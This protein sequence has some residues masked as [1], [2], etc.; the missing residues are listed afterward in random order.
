[1]LRQASVSDLI[2]DRVS[3]GKKSHVVIAMRRYPRFINR[4]LRDEYLPSLASDHE[5]FEDWLATKRRTGDHDGAFAKVKFEDRFELGE[6]GLENLER[7][8]R[9][10]RGKD[11]YV[12]C[13]C[14]RGQRCHREMVLLLAHERFGAPIE[15]VANAYPR[16]VRKLARA[17]ARPARAATARRARRAGAYRRHDGSARPSEASKVAP[18]ARSRAPRPRPRSRRGSAA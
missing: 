10:S 5:L 9:L 17:G 8:S 4:E 7:L 6:E 13:Q 14:A 16:F 12:V 3:R 1:M 11:V 2:M 15:P 18:R